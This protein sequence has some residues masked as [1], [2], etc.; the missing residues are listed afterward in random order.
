M[1]NVCESLGIETDESFLPTFLPPIRNDTNKPS[2]ESDSEEDEPIMTVYRG[3]A[4]S[5]IIITMN[6]K[7]KKEREL[8]EKNIATR[9]KSI[10]EAQI[11]LE[12]QVINNQRAQKRQRMSKND[13][14][15]AF[16]QLA[17][18]IRINEKELQDIAFL[19]NC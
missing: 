11:R 2:L 3:P 18:K 14:E 1:I 5:E 12:F 8:L 19:E 16:N 10:T 7:K 6:E 17:K 13:R 9:I 4:E 15:E